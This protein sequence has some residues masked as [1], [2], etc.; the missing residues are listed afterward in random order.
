MQYSTLPYYAIQGPA[1]Y[2]MLC[3]GSRGGRRRGREK[4][5]QGTRDEGTG[6]SLGL[7]VVWQQELEW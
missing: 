7:L 5:G 2:A 6:K 1:K 4:E 3:E